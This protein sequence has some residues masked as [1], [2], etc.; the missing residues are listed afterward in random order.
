MKMKNRRFATV[1]VL[2]AAIMASFAVS[3]PSARAQSVPKDNADICFD[4][5]VI[6]SRTTGNCEVVTTQVPC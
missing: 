6:C 2:A 1:P 5:E 3:V 4:I